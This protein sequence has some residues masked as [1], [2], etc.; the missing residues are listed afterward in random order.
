M[1]ERFLSFPLAY[2]HSIISLANPSS[3]LQASHSAGKV[4]GLLMLQ[5][6]NIITQ[7]SQQITTP[8]LNTKVSQSFNSNC[9]VAIKEFCQT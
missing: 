7:Q 1:S 3:G 2:S 6:N 9:S 8:I 4:E 5:E